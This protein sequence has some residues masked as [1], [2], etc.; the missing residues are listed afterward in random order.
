MHPLLAQE[1]PDST[2]VPSYPTLA[3]SREV[4]VAS[5][6]AGALL[7]GF[8]IPI[9]VRD[10][11]ASG[12]DPAEIML[13]V[14]RRIVGNQ[15]LD[16]ANASDWTRNTAFLL[17]VAMAAFTGPGDSRWHRM[18]RRALI[19]GE[20]FLLTMGLTTLGKAAFSRPR[21]FNYLADDE[22]L[23]DDHYDPTAERAFV[24]MPSGHASSAWTG[25]GLAITEFLLYEPEA[26]GWAK[27]GVG[28]VG[29]ALGA[30]TAALRVQAGQHFPTDVTVGSLLGLSS[31]IAVPLFHR[32]ATP[33]PSARAWL[34]AS[35]G[36]LLGSVTGVLLSGA[37][38]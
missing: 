36:M 2:A 28:F 25:S 32:G 10:V 30:S 26:S 35:G 38:F 37:F 12:L 22:R 11:P 8:L 34:Q 4:A 7:G 9:D 3:T 17:P 20:A 14:D 1:R 21:P 27:A 29:G 18:D 19:Y 16:A 13:S 24:S 5:A 6:G 15:S 31:G 23:D 33:L